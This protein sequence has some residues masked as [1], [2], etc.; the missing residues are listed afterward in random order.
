MKK[1]VNKVIHLPALLSMLLLFCALGTGGVYAGSVV[2]HVVQPGESLTAIASHY[3]TTVYRISQDNNIQNANLVKP[4]QVLRITLPDAPTSPPPAQSTST[5]TA[6]SPAAATPVPPPAPVSQDGA[7]PTPTPT[8]TRQPAAT[9]TSA[10]VQGCIGYAQNG[11]M[12][13]TVRSGDT[14]S[15]LA[16]R[17]GTSASAIKIRNCLGSDTVMVGQLLIVPYGAV[18]NTPVPPTA[19]SSGQQRSDPTFTPTRVP[20]TATPTPRPIPTSTATPSSWL[21]RLLGR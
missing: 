4:G 1:V 8:P 14:L 11:E 6:E 18:D 17:Y 9:A 19:T 21:D 5:P 15:G 20:P 7:T 16:S 12:R 13:Y 10:P 2:N 3:G